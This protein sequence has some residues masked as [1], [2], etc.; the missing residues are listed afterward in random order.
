M[1]SSARRVIIV[2]GPVAVAFEFFVFAIAC[3]FGALGGWVFVALK[4]IRK[5]K[6]KDRS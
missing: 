4:A 6:S 3:A 5:F 2:L 1:I